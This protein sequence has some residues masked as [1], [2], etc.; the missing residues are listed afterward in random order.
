MIYVNVYMKKIV[1]YMY[2]DPIEVK[3]FCSLLAVWITENECYYKVVHI[4][5]WLKIMTER[6]DGRTNSCQNFVGL[7]RSGFWCYDNWQIPSIG[8]IRDM[9]Y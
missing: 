1:V 4:E 8:L 2:I 9:I 7:M 6:L 3:E 5:T